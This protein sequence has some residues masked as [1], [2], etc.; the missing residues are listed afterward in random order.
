MA[1]RIEPEPEPP[2]AAQVELEIPPGEEKS[3]LTGTLPPS[4][5]SRGDP[6]RGDLSTPPQSLPGAPSPKIDPLTS[7]QGVSKVARAKGRMVPIGNQELTSGQEAMAL[8]L[9]SGLSQVNAYRQAFKPPKSRSR[10]AID[11]AAYRLAR[12]PKVMR[13]VK[14]MREKMIGEAAYTLEAAMEEAERAYNQALLIGQPGAAVSAVTLRARL[15]GLLV[16]DRAN[17]R[18]ALSGMT[19]KELEQLKQEATRVIEQA[20]AA[21]KKA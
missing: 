21:T 4:T 16:E 18:E 20:K 1:Q 3:P 15:H 14:E 17:A 5:E 7:S 10:S 2:K 9:A 8:A 12:H 11:A 6:M 19:D 13:R